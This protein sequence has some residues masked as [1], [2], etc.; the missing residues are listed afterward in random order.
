MSRAPRIVSRGAPGAARAVS[1]GLRLRQVFGAA[2]WPPPKAAA[3]GRS[4]LPARSRLTVVAAAALLA[5]S[6]TAAS[7]AAEAPPAA[8]DPGAGYY[9]TGFAPP[10]VARRDVSI[11]SLVRVAVLSVFA[12]GIFSV[13]N[14][15]YPDTRFVDTDRA[16]WSAV[17]LGGGLVSLAV[18]LLVPRFYVGFPL[19]V[20]MFAGAAACYVVHRNARV[21]PPLRVLSRAHLA[22]VRGTPPGSRSLRRGASPGGG[23]VPRP[24]VAGPGGESGSGVAFLGYD[25]LPR[26]PEAGSFEQQRA[27]QEWERILREAIDRDASALGLIVRRQQG[28]VRFRVGG[29]MEAGPRLDPALA[30]QVLRLIK[31][32]TD[33][34]PD[35]TRKP[36]ESRIQAVVDGRTYDLRIKTAGTVR[37]E[38]AAVRIRDQ[39]MTRLRLEDLGL[40]EEQVLTLKQAL[41]ERPGVVLVSAPKHA[42]L[43]TTLHACLR[44]FDRYVNDVVALEPQVDLEVESVEH[45]PL[46]QEDGPVA[47][48]AVRGR[49]HSEPD[50]VAVDALRDA[51]VARTLAE[52]DD[53]LTL[54]VGLRAGDTSQALSRLVELLGTTAPL[55]ERLRVVVNQRLVRL[56]C[57]ECKEAYRPNPEFLRKANLAVDAARML[58]RPPARTEVTPKGEVLVCPR[59]RNHRYVGRTGLFELM[60][61]DAEA[62]DL[63][64]CNALTDLRTHCRKLGMRN[65]QEEGLRLVLD[66]RTSVEEVL[67]A[68]K[69][70]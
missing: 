49:L 38:Q 59:C 63:I 39:A 31:G 8:T 30:A 10:E 7:A 33:L 69:T 6:L 57:P 65:L 41:D 19:G 44:Y 55:A 60:P 15:V 12:A 32:L 36:Q 61:I 52:A 67:R 29:E 50:V 4:R 27:C 18:A 42:G 21:T 17:V 64:A 11:G 16:L 1:R 34:D 2:G 46:D 28:D 47:A 45:V 43:T 70:D 35:E 48:S 26:Q 24:P 5:V 66:G 37:G 62:R 54:V 3:H 23:N 51:D 20:A 22:R 68:I 14:W 53:D 56:L 58:Y 40:T 9:P 25:D 13:A